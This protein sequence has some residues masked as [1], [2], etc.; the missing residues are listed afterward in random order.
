MRI[1]GTCSPRPQPRDSCRPMR[2]YAQAAIASEIET[3]RRTSSG[4]ACAAFRAAA[5]VGGFIAVGEMN[6]A[7]AKDLLLAAALETGL[8][9]SEAIGHIQRGIRR[10]EM[11]PRS[12]PDDRPGGRFCSPAP[13]RPAIDT[14]DRNAPEHSIARP[15]KAEIDALWAA[16]QPVGSDPEVAKWFRYRY[17][18]PGEQSATPRIRPGDAEGFCY[19]YRPSVT[20]ERVELWDLARA[21]PAGL[22][23]PHWA[24]SRGGPWTRTG[25]RVLFR[26]WD[27]RGRAISLRARCI[28]PAVAP[29]SLAPSG[30][31]TKGLVLADSMGLQLLTDTV[32]DWWDPHEI[33]ISEGEVDFVTW[34]TRQSEADPNGP[35]IFAV[36]AGA[37]SASIAARIPDGSAVVVRTHH[38]PPGERYAEQ[39]ADTLHGRCRVFRSLPEEEAE[40]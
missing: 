3:L 39:I 33:I 21:I 2:P 26:L 27:A 19:R 18:P 37:W 4:R 23:L 9:E 1:R 36:E 13:N 32:P 15:P 29:K 5:A 17:H 35:A 28:D 30:F 7:D 22:D 38:D 11:T 34:A 40:R 10:G 20:I 6:R 12:I 16:S 8:P 31:S 14:A 24:R 25:H